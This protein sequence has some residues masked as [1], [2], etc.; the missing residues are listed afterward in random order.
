MDMRR[1]LR[2]HTLSSRSSMSTPLAFPVLDVACL[3]ITETPSNRLKNTDDVKIGK[4]YRRGNHCRNQSLQQNNHMHMM[5][6]CDLERASQ[7]IY[8]IRI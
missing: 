8:S 4:D 3:S 2:E 5:K 7:L 1:K 6:Q